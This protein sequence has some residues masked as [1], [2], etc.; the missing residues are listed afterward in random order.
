MVIVTADHG[1]ADK[2]LEKSKSGDM[3]V[4]TAHSLN[5]VPFILWDSQQERK[6]KDGSFGLA[7]CAATVA[8]LFGLTP[9]DCW[10]ES[11]LA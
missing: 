6:L 4:R 7:N 11:M 2:M 1:N 3:T 9:P 5:P 8:E 10:E